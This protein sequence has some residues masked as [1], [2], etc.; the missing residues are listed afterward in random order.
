[1][2]CSPTDGNVAHRLKIV[3]ALTPAGIAIAEPDG[4]P[5]PDGLRHYNLTT[6]EQLDQRSDNIAKGLI[7]WGVKPGMR[8]GML[9]PFGGQFIE[10]VFA[11]LKTGAVAV[12]IDPGI[13]KKHLVK[14]LSESRPDGFVGI[15]KAQM[16]RSV[17]RKHFPTAKWNVTVGRRWFWGGKTLDQIMELGQKADNAT[18]P[19]VDQTDQAA[20]IFTTG[21]T[22]PPKGVLYTHGT[23][24]AQI[25]RIRERYDIHRGSRD[26]ACFPLFGLFD[27][28]MGVTTI[29]PD[30]D[31]TRPADVNP[32]RLIE[33][34]N[35]WEVDQ[36]FGS[37]ALWNTVV[38]WCENNKVERPFPTLRRVLSAGA[39]VP[40]VTLEKLRTLID[41]DAMIVTP[42]G[43]TEALPIA[44]IESREVIA[45]TGPATA[46]GKGV[47]VGSRFEGVQWRVIKIEDGPIDDISETSEMPR[48]KIGE[49]MV[50]GP[51]VTTEYVVRSDQN[52]MH[53]VRDGD[54]VWHRMGDV[55]YLDDR[56][57]FW[58]CGR[59]AHRV[60]MENRT[61]FTIPCEAVFNSHPSVYRSALVGKGQRPNQI[62]V[63]MVETFAKDQ[64]NN[65]TEREALQ[66]ELLDLAA[67]N[68][69][70]RRIE[71]III[72]TKPLPVDIR[73]NSKIFRE[74]LSEEIQSKV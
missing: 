45:E 16:I 32:M 55:G 23:F 57:R 44:S 63:V 6:F 50:S 30:M 5:R 33:A 1:M 48:G 10:L 51:M 68:P 66:A 41:P 12:L 31:P 65:D 24:H 59:K 34:A 35:Q 74:R 47:C 17:L 60:V 37:P 19:K 62:P 21:S 11:L 39:P 40:A 27:A 69:I 20:I 54:R 9:V 43:A 71:E 28:V 36:A 26:L 70:T 7:A 18:L 13:G 56:D 42:Y 49:L 64:P 15:P 25:E 58:F 4:P 38:T 22:G 53:K 46:K 29:I 67:R 14:C 73:H 52:P 72:R 3:S 61:L 2:N 8:L